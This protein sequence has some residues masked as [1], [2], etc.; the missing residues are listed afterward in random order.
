MV[1]VDVAVYVPCVDVII[2]EVGNGDV[3]M[4]GNKSMLM[5]DV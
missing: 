2:D 3:L 1:V 4:L 5:V